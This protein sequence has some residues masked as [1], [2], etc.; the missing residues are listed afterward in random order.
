MS[1][2]FAFD[3]LCAA[4]IAAAGCSIAI[5]INQV[6]IY[7]QNQDSQALEVQK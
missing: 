3:L 7:I 2:R 5:G 6:L 1:K 4:M